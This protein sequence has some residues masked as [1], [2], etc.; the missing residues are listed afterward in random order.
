MYFFVIECN[1]EL[2]NLSIL[3]MY[4]VQYD[5]ATYGYKINWIFIFANH[6]GISLMLN[7]LVLIFDGVHF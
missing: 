1:Y 7:A 3:V 2:T 5:A 6:K 4:D